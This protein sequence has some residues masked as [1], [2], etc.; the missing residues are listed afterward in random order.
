[1]VESLYDNYYD[2]LPNVQ[3]SI[4]FHLPVRLSFLQ[5]YVKPKDQRLSLP[6]NFEWFQAEN[7]LANLWNK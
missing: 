5:S 7:R 2:L 4:L 6:I 3:I 1:M